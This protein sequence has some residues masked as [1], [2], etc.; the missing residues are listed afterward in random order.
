MFKSNTF[1]DTLGAS[2]LVRHVL[3]DAILWALTHIDPPFNEDEYSVNQSCEEETIP[4]FESDRIKFQIIVCAAGNALCLVR[5]GA[6]AQK[7]IR[8]VSRYYLD[9]A[10]S[11]NLSAA[12]VARTEDMG[13][14][15]FELYKKLNAVKSSCEVSNP[16][17]TLAIVMKENKTGEPVVAFDKENQD[18]ISASS[19]IRR[20][21][22]KKRAVLIGKDEIRGTKGPDGK[23]YQAIIHADGNNLGITIG[24]IL[25]NTRS[26][27]EGIRIRRLI[28]KNISENYTRV[29]TGA[30]KRLREYYA[31]SGKNAEDFPREFQL[32][33]QAGDDVNIICNADLAF[34]FTEYFY[35]K[36]K[37][38]FLMQYKGE[39]IPLYVCTGIAF[40]N[41]DI[42]YH[43]A[44][45]FAEE[46]CESAKTMAKKEENLRNGLAGNWIDFQ[47]YDTQNSQKLDMLRL[48]EFIT[49]EG[50]NLALRPY[51]F[52]ETVEEEPYSYYNFRRRSDKI[53]QLKL[54]NAQ[55][56]TLMLSYNMGRK[57]FNKYI[58]QLKS[59][60][61]DLA[62][63][64]GQPL[65]KQ[66]DKMKAVWFDA[67]KLQCFFKKAGEEE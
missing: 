63:I 11:L 13:R 52:D 65:Y 44:F 64:L 9:H 35:E 38:A 20:Q 19:V 10:Y 25:Q 17:G 61:I 14:D 41:K 5:T 56:R 7:I 39:D 42:D 32:I 4:Y 50:I 22:S 46:C 53:K 12:A 47:V 57:N 1:Y 3:D 29:V 36:M 59:S 2:D 48:K 21:E 40:V 26:Y 23:E 33:H 67:F 58:L 24:R 54:T 6:L 55:Y 16:L 66:G 18:Y 60:G 8:R 31:E 30:I 49:Y 51:C 15:I 28:N 62:D 45:S 43:T 37:G 34:I 27:E